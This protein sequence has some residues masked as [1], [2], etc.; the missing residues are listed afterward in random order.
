[1]S[2]KLDVNRLENFVISLNNLSNETKNN[3]ATMRSICDPSC[4][5]P[6]CHGGLIS[7]LKLTELQDLY[8]EDGYS[9]RE[10]GDVLAEYLGF[11][12]D[13][14]ELQ[15]YFRDHWDLWGNT[16]AYG[17]FSHSSAFN[18]DSDTFPHFII[19]DW[20]G[21][22]LKRV[23]KAEAEKPWRS[24]LRKVTRKTVNMLQD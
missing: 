9:F 22:V 4:G 23:K 16:N 18:Q 3:P 10:W 17:M 14:E 13:R 19:I 15:D 6:G 11:A 2:K 21:K 24:Y 20:W 8:K 12:H 5:T 7:L 1:M